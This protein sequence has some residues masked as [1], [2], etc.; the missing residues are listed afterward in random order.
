MNV[1]TA[2]LFRS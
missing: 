2:H 1:R